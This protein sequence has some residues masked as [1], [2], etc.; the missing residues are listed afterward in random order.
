MEWNEWISRRRQQHG[1]KSNERELRS[2]LE[3]EKEKKSCEFREGSR[4]IPKPSFKTQFNFL[5]FST[6]SP[7]G[8]S[9]LVVCLRDEWGGIVGFSKFRNSIFNLFSSP[10][11][12]E[13]GGRGVAQI[14]NISTL[15]LLTQSSNS[16][17]LLTNNEEWDL[18][19]WKRSNLVD[20]TEST[21]EEMKKNEKREKLEFHQADKNSCEK[22]S[23]SPKPKFQIDTQQLNGISL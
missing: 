11:N 22:E 7:L 13:K 20:T 4:S 2:G 1:G 23:N 19:W 5:E 8:S 10:K 16:T 9:V 15:S 21:N 14:P 12:S 6:L 18:R 17:L 3:E